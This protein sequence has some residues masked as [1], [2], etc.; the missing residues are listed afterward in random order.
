MNAVHKGPTPWALILCRFSN[1]LAPDVPNTYYENFIS[2][3]GAGTGGMFD[4]W[5]DISSGTID[6]T[7]SIVKGWYEMDL[8]FPYAW[9]VDRETI[10]NEAKQ[11]AAQDGVDLSPY[12][13]I[14]AAINAN[15]GDGNDGFHNVVVGIGGSWGDAHWKQCYKCQGLFYAGSGT[16]V[17]HCPATGT[18]DGS[19]SSDYSVALNLPDF[20]GQASWRRCF[21]CLGLFFGEHATNHPCPAGGSHNEAGSGN[22][23]L[24]SSGAHNWQDGWRWCKKC[25]GLF[26]PAGGPIPCPDGGT[27]DGSESGNYELTQNNDHLNPTF[28]GHEM[29]HAYALGHS[30]LNFPETEYGDPFDIM[31][32]IRVHT[33]AGAYGSGGPGMT[34]VNLDTLGWIPDA[35]IRTLD[36]VPETAATFALAALYDQDPLHQIPPRVLRV[37]TPDWLF[38]VEF[39][40][41]TGWDRGFPRPGVLIHVARTLYNRG[42]TGWR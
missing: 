28:V 11:L 10:I 17:G 7:G 30:W 39:R 8:A 3:S 25:Q 5:R 9:D 36:A 4:Y 18:H 12:Y 21:K 16:Q 37:V 27:H 6:L 29:G 19:A 1:V 33:V 20:P 31:S 32:A 2:E 26:L 13:G 22:Y 24:S 14:L 41:A 35:R 23:G 38:T 40:D 15:I 42:Q 34:A